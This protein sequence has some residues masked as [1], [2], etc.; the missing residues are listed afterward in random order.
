[1]DQIEERNNRE[2]VIGS[3]EYTHNINNLFDQLWAVSSIYLRNTDSRDKYT[4]SK[5]YEK[6]VKQAMQDLG[7]MDVSGKLT[8]DNPFDFEYYA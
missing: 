8:I 1:M 5:E 4:C 6:S 2:D 3:Y 7:L